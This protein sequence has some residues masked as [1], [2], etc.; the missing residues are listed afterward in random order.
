FSSRCIGL[1]LAALTVCLGAHAHESSQIVVFGH[2][3]N[4]IGSSDSAS[5]GVIG[6][7]LLSNRALLRP[8]EVLEYIPG[9]VV[10][11]HS[12]D[13]KANQYFLRGMNLD[14]GTDFATTVNGVPIN[15]PSHGHGHGYSDLNVL[16]PELVSRIQYRKGPYFAAEG[17][18]SSAGSASIMYR[19][20]LDKP[21]AAVSVGQRGYLRAIAA[22]SREIADGV[23][24]LAAVER[25]NND[26]PWTTP[27]GLR[28]ANLLFTVSGGTPRENWSTS[29]SAY[30]AYWN[31]TDQVPQRLIDAGSYLGRPFGRFDSLD[32]SD[33][34]RT[35]RL[36]LSGNWQRSRDDQI[37]A[38]QWYLIKYDLD[39]YSNFTY[40]LD[41]ASDQF[42]QKDHRSVLGANAFRTWISDLGSERSML[43][44][45]GVQVRQDQIRVGLFDTV[46]RQIEG[47]V[48]DD[49]VRQTILGIYGQ[50]ELKW[51]SW[52]RTLA[53][54]RADQ[55]QA[56][57]TSF[58]LAENTG[59]A[60]AFKVS[61]KMSM[62]FGPWHKTELFVN[63][64]RGFHSNDARGMVARIDPKT[65]LEVD[66]V[67]G[68]V[69]SRGREIGVKTEVI[70]HLQSA[71]AFWKLD[72]DSELV[73]VGD[74]GNTEASR[75]SRRS[76]IEWSNHWTP[77]EQVLVDVNLAWTRPR[78]ADND[79]AGNAIVNATQRV[80][81]LTFA[82]RNLG[83]WSGS[84]GVRY[85]G[86]AP[87]IEDNSVRSLCSV[88]TNLRAIR[89]VT[90]D[91]QVAVDVLNLAD[92]KNNDISYYYTSRVAGEPA[93]GVDGVHVHPAEPRTI[94]VTARLQF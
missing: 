75:P 18:F 74:A 57:V 10:T 47:A 91:I 94:R 86:S 93:A 8:A 6:P 32:P 11:Q 85:I 55:L 42:A 63:A 81:N 71:I 73:Y 54:I 15:M 4:D 48:R 84:L 60:S 44:T 27:E 13:G 34:A 37:T 9:M 12:G 88:T 78:Y 38:L 65:G 46:Q 28:K 23:T 26:G 67:P 92:R 76:G 3:A 33:G 56:D 17:D 31:S 80:A 70:P 30:S 19:S 72:F 59:S 16:I 83:L 52:F 35:S 68:L 66:R 25:L 24:L 50:N 40:A 1:K 69:S 58:V 21:I 89:R 2:Y 61:P 39:L 22:G 5:Q 90:N 64:G 41:R 45:L 79:P 51:T 14:H 20:Q 53:G 62:I 36:S 29:L 7:E 87:L 77:N 82:L 43:N 49:R